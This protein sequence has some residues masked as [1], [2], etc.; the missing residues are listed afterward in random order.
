MIERIFQSR[1][2]DTDQIPKKGSAET[3]PGSY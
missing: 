2:G 1:M 3:K